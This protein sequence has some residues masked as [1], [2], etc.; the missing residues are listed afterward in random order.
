M[1]KIHLLWIVLILMPGILFLVWKVFNGGLNNMAGQKQEHGKHPYKHGNG[2]HRF[3]D[4]EKWAKRF[5]KPQRDEWQKPDE[6]IR[7]LNLNESSIVADIGSATGYF[8]VRFAEALPEG[9]VYGVDTEKSMVDFLNSR[10]RRD[11]LS[12]LSSLLGK[13]DDPEIPEPVDVVFICNT[14]HHINNRK[15]YFSKMKSIFRPGG[16][17]VVVD[18]KKGEFPVGPPDEMKLLVQTVVSELSD[19]GYRL[20]K[21]S[22]I[23]PYQYFLIF[24]PEDGFQDSLP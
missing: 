14:Y 23:L 10:A 18:F 12:N 3:K 11:G 2:Q 1:R 9:R 4:A 22:D 8:P 7:A 16:R 24:Q 20:V 15:Q 6:V 13:P 21:K 17:L 5:E 19:A